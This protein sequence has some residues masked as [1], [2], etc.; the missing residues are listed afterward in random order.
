MAMC[1][2]KAVAQ[3]FSHCWSLDF[4]EDMIEDVGIEDVGSMEFYFFGL[5]TFITGVGDFTL[6]STHWTTF[7]NAS[8]HFAK[9]GKIPRLEPTAVE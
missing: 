2:E 1:V 4:N 3:P 9:N 8:K 6:S 7:L 5:L